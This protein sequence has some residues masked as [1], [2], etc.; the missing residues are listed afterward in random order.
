M[1]PG[2]RE[3]VL[4]VFEYFPKRI[5]E[6]EWKAQQGIANDKTEE[7]MAAEI[8]WLFFPDAYSFLEYHWDLLCPPQ[9][10]NR[11][12]NFKITISKINHCF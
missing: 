4:A 3:T 10:R 1:N 9:H 12:C 11:T 7:E 5:T 2:W 8:R 6:S